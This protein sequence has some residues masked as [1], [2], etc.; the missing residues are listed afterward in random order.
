MAVE[1]I[2]SKNLFY[3]IGETMKLM[4]EPL[5][6]H[7]ERVS[8]IMS[9]MLECKGG[10]E[11]YEIA[12]F[13]ILAMLHDMG[14]HRTDNVRKP[15]SF[16]TKNPLPHSIYG[17]LALKYL[18]PLEEQSKMILYHHMDYDTTKNLD[19]KYKDEL[20]I[21]K[22]AEIIDIWHGAFADKFNHKLLDRYKGTKYSPDAC[23]LLYDAV[24]KY[25]IFSKIEDGSYRK[26]Y[27]ESVEYVLLSDEEKEKY[28]KLLMYS[29]GFKQE[30]MVPETIATIYVSRELGRKLQISELDKNEIYYAALLHD[31]G[32][33]SIPKSILELPRKLTKEELNLVHTHVETMEKALEGR[34]SQSIID[35]ASAHHERFDGSGYPRGLKGSAMN[36]KQAILQIAELVINMGEPK[37]Y[38]EAYSKEQIIEELNNGIIS[39]KYEGIVAD[40]LLRNYDEIMDKAM[41]RAQVALTMYKKLKHNF[42]QVYK[43]FTN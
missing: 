13:M 5:A 16:E 18:S 34:L 12:N 2:T 33:L 35:I 26:E 37:S 30:S 10:Y 27:E 7:C 20:E 25:D 9:R 8:Y 24:D 43:N 28:I 40:T 19:Y 31:I 32:M 23:Q 14:A 38:R 6:K 21:L 15:L 22:V 39:G 41:Q 1:Y 42:Q 29:T 17:Y 11:K 36:T 3:L 4:D